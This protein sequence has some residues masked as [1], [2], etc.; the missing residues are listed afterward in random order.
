MTQGWISHIQDNKHTELEPAKSQV[1]ISQMQDR[2]RVELYD[3]V[4][5][6]YIYNCTQLFGNQIIYRFDRYYGI[7]Q[8]TTLKLVNM[9]SCLPLDM[10]P[11]PREVKGMAKDFFIMQV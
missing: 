1:Y 11:Y 2:A 6:C 9:K 8:N 3:H 10:M 7:E 4:T 5:N